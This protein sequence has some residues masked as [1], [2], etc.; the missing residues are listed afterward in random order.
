MEKFRP[1]KKIINI[2]V[3]LDFGT[4]ATKI[5]YSQVGGRFV[6]AVIFNHWLPNYPVFALPSVIAFDNQDR[7]LIGI[8]AAKHLLDKPWQEGV[9]RSKMIV[10]GKYDPSFRESQTEQAFHQY[11]E[12]HKKDPAAYTPERLTAIYLAYAMR[13]AR[14]ALKTAP[15]YQ[16]YDL[17]IAFNICMPIDHL[18]NNKVK[19]VFE[20][21]FAWAEAIEAGWPQNDK[22]PDLLELSGHTENSVSFGHPEAR[23]FAIPEA[24]AEIVSYRFSLQQT[25]G[26]H[27]V[28]DFGAGTTDVSIFNL[29]L[30]D[31]FQELKDYWYSARNIPWGMV[32]IEQALAEMMVAYLRTGRVLSGNTLA[33]LLSSLESTGAFPLDE[34]LKQAMRDQVKA[35]F[36]E[37]WESR[38]YKVKAW[39]SAYGKLKRQLAWENVK[40]FVGGGGSTAP[41]VK[42][43]F[44]VP[45]CYPTVRGPYPVNPLPEP[46]NFYSSNG[47]TPFHRLAVAYG[48]C[49]P[50]P[51][52][53]GYVL[54]GDCP[55]QTPFR[56]PIWDGYNDDNLI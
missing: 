13:Q 51:L 28:I 38:D 47:R 2:Q 40:I 18:E 43:V 21:I 55:D 6:R 46:A 39:G 4:S 41:Y 26:L 32:K 44:S 17:D 54:P 53:N 37:L 10:A 7:L 36:K 35:K 27:A 45:W 14:N 31:E 8:D 15:E 3:G 1:K 24:V 11:L 52:L 25:P 29:S 49:F 16:N 48:L 23:V 42:Q 5:A 33:E 50:K 12:I 19:P 20:N 9:Q 30:R 22:S 34:S 56:L